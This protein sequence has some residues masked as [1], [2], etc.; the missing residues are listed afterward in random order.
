M[1]FKYSIYTVMLNALPVAIQVPW[2]WH[3]ENEN[4]PTGESQWGGFTLQYNRSVYTA[5]AS[6]NVG[7][8]LVAST[9]NETSLRH[10]HTS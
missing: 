7:S 8:S 10:F 1:F 9:I 6:D 3:R 5:S 4:R 2:C